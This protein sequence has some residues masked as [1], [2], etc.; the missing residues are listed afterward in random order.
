MKWSCAA[1]SAFA[2]LCSNASAQCVGEWLPSGTPAG[3]SGVVYALTTW[4]SDGAGPL[5]TRLVVGGAFTSV[6]GVSANRVAL[7][8]PA[9]QTWS[10]LGA[11]VNNVVYALTTLPTGELVAG[12]QF[13]TAGGNP[14]PYIAKWNGTTWSALGSGLGGFGVYALHTRSNGELLAGG[15]FTT[16]GGASANYI[17]KWNGATWSALG[18]G[19]NNFVY[20]ITEGA[21]GDIYA[22]GNFTSAGGGAASKIARWDGSSWNA[23]GAGTNFQVYALS[24]MNSGDI[25]AA[26][27]FTTA[28]G[29]SANHIARWSPTTSTW[30]ALG[31]GIGGDLY[32]L[33]IM[34]NG[35]VVAGGFFN[36]AG[37]VPANS[38]ARWN[39]SVWSALGPGVSAMTRAL[40][41][42]PN[43]ELDAGGEF[44]TAGAYSVNR[45]ARYITPTPFISGEPQD[46]ATCLTG[47]AQISTVAGGNGPF[48]YAWQWSHPSE[49]PTWTAVTSGT[50][51]GINGPLFDASGVSASQLS[52]DPSGSDIQFSATLRTTPLQVRCVVSTACGS[53]T[54]RAANM[55]ICPGNFNCDATLDFFDYLDFVAAFSTNDPAA[56]FNGDETIDFFDYL[57]F[58]AAF[59]E[60][61]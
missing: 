42:M 41:V 51:S 22:G 26:G 21:N 53:V 48:A 29:A 11:G 20:A 23:M 1:I 10:A 27:L 31:G 8:D 18:S 45:F 14:I 49:Q 61:C 37:V 55:R 58:V 5:P 9:T 19:M 25:I 46:L 24:R 36:I 57:D 30:S 56:D 34:P 16:A 28:G 15:T 6:G 50:N 47:P 17:A 60:G 54:S 7:Y 4:D 38:V 59:S 44:L 52:I 3:A 13:T 40:A 2:G 39:G 12:G 32:A 33:Q 35:D 43:G